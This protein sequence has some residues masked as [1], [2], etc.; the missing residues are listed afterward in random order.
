MGYGILPELVDTQNP[1]VITGY[2][3]SQVWFRTESTVLQKCW[4]F[5]IFTRFEYL[6]HGFIAA[7]EIRLYMRV[8]PQ[9]KTRN[10]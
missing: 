1:W 9:K 10:L 7:R 3:L 8:V 6:N 5:Q 2:G 4:I